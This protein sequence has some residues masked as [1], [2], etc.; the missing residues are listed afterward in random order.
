MEI[1]GVILFFIVGAGVGS[2]DNVIAYRYPRGKSLF[3]LKKN[4]CEICKHELNVVDML[5]IMGY[6]IR[7]GRC[8]YCDEKISITHPISEAVT[9]ILFALLFLQYGWS[10]KTLAGCIM[11]AA[12]L[13]QFVS[14]MKYA[15]TL[16]FVT[17][18]AV[19]I[20]LICSNLINVGWASA[21]CGIGVF[22]VIYG[23]IYFFSRKTMGLSD[24]KM[25]SII[26]AFSGLP[27]A[28]L[29]FILSS[30]MAAVVAVVS[31]LFFRKKRKIHLRFAPF[32]LISGFI[33]YTYTAELINLYVSFFPQQ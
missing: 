3:F 22:A 16:N 5:P 20:G 7:G 9:G 27:G 13:I 25:A 23:I 17:Y 12:L 24:M 10:I 28:F 33:A 29:T 31:M 4:Q 11:T 2:F 14:E 32:L 8:R 21:L 1:I 18:I 26:A 30:F 15:K 19:I 6:F